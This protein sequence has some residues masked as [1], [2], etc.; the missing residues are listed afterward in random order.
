MIYG[1]S[2]LSITIEDDGI[3]FEFDKIKLREGIGLKN[4]EN[5]VYYLNGK[6]T[7]ESNPGKGTLILVDVRV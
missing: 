7:I 5:R 1:D 6:L 2:N 3:G 4:I